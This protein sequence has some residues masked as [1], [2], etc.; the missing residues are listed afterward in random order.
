MRISGTELSFGRSSVAFAII[1]LVLSPMTLGGALGA[2][3]QRGGPNGT[4]DPGVGGENNVQIS[5]RKPVVFQGEDNIDFVDADGNAIDSAQLI[6]VAGDAEGQPL[7]TP[8]PTDQP[9]GQYALNGQAAQ[10]GVTVQR[11][12]V[13][14]LDILNERGIDVA[15][16]TVQEDEVLLVRADWNFRQAEDLEIVVRDEDGNDVTGAVINDA[17]QLSN[18]QRQQLSGPFAQSPEAV[19]NPGQRGTDTGIVYLQGVGQFN[20]SQLNNTQV[21]SAFWALD[22]SDLDSGDYTITVEGWDDLDFGPASR[23]TSVSVTTE[24]DVS[25]DLDQSSATRGE[26]VGYTIRGSTAGAE[27]Y[28]VIERDEFRND[29]VDVDVFRDIQDVVARGSSDTNDDG[30]A[31]FAWAQVQI[32]DDTGLGMGQI[33]TTF[34]D[35]ASIEVKLFDADQPLADVT[36]NLDDT[37]DDKTLQVDQGELEFTSPVGSYVAGSEV[38]VRGNA[39]PGV[40]DVVVYAR[41]QG[42]WELLD[43]NEDGTLDDGDL[44]SVDSAGEWE[45]EDVVLSQASDIFSIPG[46]YRIGVVEAQDARGQNGQLRTQLST[47]EFSSATSSQSALLVQEPGLEEARSFRVI[48][49]QIAVEDGTVDIAGTAPG[50]DE[51]LVAMVDSR[52]RVATERVTVDDDDTFD[53]DDIPLVTREG[54]QLNEGAIRGLILGLGR[55]N[56]AGDGILPGQNSASLAAVES[57]IQD[58]G[59]GLTQEQVFERIRDETT[60]EVASDDLSIEESFRFT[61]GSTTIEAVGPVDRFQRSEVSDVPVNSTMRIQGLTNRKPDDNT[62]S[63]EVID[64]PS[65]EAFDVNSTDEWGLDGAWDVSLDTS[66]VEPGTYTLE[67][68]DGDNTDT[69]QVTLVEEGIADNV[70]DNETTAENETAA[71]G[72]ATATPTDNATTTPADN[73]TTPAGGNATA[74]PEGNETMTPADNETAPEGGNATTPADN[75][76]AT[77]TANDTAASIVFPDQES[78]GTSVDAGQL[79]LSEGGFVAIHDA[80]LLDGNVVGSLVGVSAFLEPGDYENTSNI[81]LFNVPGVETNQTALT[82]DQTLIAMPHRDTNNNLQFDFAASNGTEDGPF[83]VDGQ[84]VI[85]AA[86]VTIATNESG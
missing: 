51:V 21:D 65:V 78:D 25:L 47:S 1:I 8:I 69:V 66:G 38:D 2:T 63:V 26:N 62:I 67:A 64:G 30:T 81:Q 28:V 61:D 56:V 27:H 10:P 35:D 79:N 37:E 71:G 15:G 40:D 85:D 3:V 60:D 74:T 53:E 82:E 58:F 32:D 16:S 70:T 57:Y 5:E 41:D 6:G 7:E 11:P 39:A 29:N 12:R 59:A 77:P 33:D 45:E 84:P 73:E 4:H 34:L 19:S 36:E 48:N 75:E 55:D 86:N 54:R 50:L 22:M 83:T 31:D 72:N 14:D 52:G 20:E 9:P 13:T 44:I 80:S 46:R 42:D 24:T 76:T 23:T 43:I 17:E 68:D 18:A 49:G